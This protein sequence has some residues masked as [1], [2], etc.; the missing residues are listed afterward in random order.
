MISETGDALARRVVN[1]STDGFAAE[2]EGA[3]PNRAQS[4]T[5][6]LRAAGGIEALQRFQSAIAGSTQSAEA[7]DIHLQSVAAYCH[8]LLNS[9]TFFLWT[10][11]NSMIGRRKRIPTTRTFFVGVS[12]VRSQVGIY[13]AALASLLRDQQISLGADAAPAVA[14]DLNARPPHIPAR[15]TSSFIYS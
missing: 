10:E 6:R 11:G 1:G 9:A 15:A 13:G 8:V 3:V 4:A 2:V 7:A 14:N 5:A 12:Y